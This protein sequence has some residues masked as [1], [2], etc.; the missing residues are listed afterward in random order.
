MMK[1]KMQNNAISVFGIMQNSAAP[2]VCFA[3]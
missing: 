2:G 1:Y 3:K